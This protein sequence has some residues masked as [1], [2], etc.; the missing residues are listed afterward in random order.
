[1]ALEPGS[2]RG[3]IAYRF[4]ED[5]I[6]PLEIVRKPFFLVLSLAFSRKKVAK[7]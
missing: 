6:P 7:I 1:M 2:G 3:A 4:T 5:I